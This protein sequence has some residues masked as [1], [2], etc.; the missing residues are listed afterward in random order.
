MAR[1]ILFVCTGNVCRSPLAEA[2]LRHKLVAR[3]VDHL[4]VVDSAGTMA[5]HLGQQADARMRRTAAARGIRIDHRARRVVPDDL[6]SFDLVIGM[7]DWHLA[8]LR[9]LADGGRVEIRKLRE[10]D[11]TTAE[12][13]E[14]APDVPDPWYGGMDGFERVYEMVERSCEHLVHRLAAAS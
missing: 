1:R 9:S 2:L 7:D 3:G 6:T 11:P 12:G 10:F 5:D 4:F 8:T 14:G 13:G